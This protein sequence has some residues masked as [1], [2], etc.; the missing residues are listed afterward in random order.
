MLSFFCSTTIV[1]YFLGG[2]LL[3]AVSVSMC[4]FACR[5]GVSSI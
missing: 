3:V 5:L 1:D 4:L 2:V